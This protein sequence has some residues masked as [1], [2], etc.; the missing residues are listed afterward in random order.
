MLSNGVLVQ[1]SKGITID[2]CAMSYAQYGGGGGNGYSYR[3]SANE[4]LISNSTAS[5]VRHGFV[6]SSMWCS[7]NV[8]HKCKDIKTG[9]QTGNT[10]N[11][12]T[13][14]W[15]SDHHMH[16]SQSNLIDQ[17]Y[18][19]N[20][21]YVAFYRPYGSVPKHNLTATHTAFWNT[22]SAG[23]RGYC[24]WTQQSRYGYAIGTSG[25]SSTIKTNENSAGSAAKT[26]PVDIAEG[27]GQGAS[28][29]PQS[30][31][32][33]QL[34]KRLNPITLKVNTVSLIDAANGSVIEGYENIKT[35]TEINRSL[36]D[37]QD[38]NI[39]AESTL[40]VDSIVFFHTHEGTT[41]RR[42][43][44]SAP[45]ALRGDGSA[46]QAWT[47]PTGVHEINITAYSGGI[48]SETLQLVFTVNDGPITSLINNT[49]DQHIKVFP[50]PTTHTLSVTAFQPIKEIVIYNATN[51]EVFSQ[52]L[53]GVEYTKVISLSSLKAGIYFIKVDG[54]LQKFIKQ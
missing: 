30:L 13:A 42:K 17:C 1:F 27:Q 20:S 46:Y 54:Q 19:E 5:Y 45:F 39:Y 38:F 35:V 12:S 14:G 34:N 9:F 23:S 43:E 26:N 48:A 50:N 24:V 7:G 52:T 28:L 40:A 44:S 8:F 15:G 29:V 53:R 21:A 2:N 37:V 11:M 10:G 49:E 33:D 41:L 16:F 25:T 47:L 32:M 36:I 51:Q 3:V 4:V 6:F 18:S 22:S 31:Y